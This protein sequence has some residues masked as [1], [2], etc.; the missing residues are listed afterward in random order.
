MN[1]VEVTT[2]VRRLLGALGLPV[3]YTGRIVVGPYELNVHR[4]AV[5]RV[6]TVT[7]EEVPITG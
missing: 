2:H 6:Y 7:R 4:G 5:S 1:P 3:D